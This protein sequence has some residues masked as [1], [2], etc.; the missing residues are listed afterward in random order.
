MFRTFAEIE[1][2]IL[3]SHIQ[4]RIALMN[5]H[6]SHSLPALAA[7]KKKGLVTAVLLGDEACIK[8][9]LRECGEAPGDYEI[10]HN[11]DDADCARQGVALIREGKA[12]YPMKGLMQTSD[13]MHA[14]LDK[15][16]GLLPPGALLSQ[17]TIVE[18][19]QENRFFLVSDCAINI[20]P[21]YEQKVKIIQNA[22]ALAHSL[23]YA[24]PKVAVLSAL[25]M[26]NPKI[27]STLEAA[28]LQEA[29]EKGEMGQCIVAGPLALDNAISPEA[30]A[31]KGL[32][33]PVAGN[34]D[35]LIV[36]DLAAGNIFAKSLIFFGKMNSA[37][38]LL[39]TS[40]P[41]IAAS[42]TDTPENKYN[43][44]LAALLRDIPH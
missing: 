27:P 30:A 37:G 31:H 2:S 28:R 17:A 19:P 1:K 40:T 25:E 42:R 5:A 10:I 22:V 29:G 16:Q 21:G 3:D 8:K 44:I 4:K 36:P 43:A 7:A 14:I 32:A 39:G 13:F 20:A 18:Y 15:E 34:A 11:T 41:V 38:T 26:V 9:L 24:C 23:G 12:D 6:D 33:G 35:I